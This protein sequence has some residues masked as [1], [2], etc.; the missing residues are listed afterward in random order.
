M[1][2]KCCIDSRTNSSSVEVKNSSDGEPTAVKTTKTTGGLL[3]RVKS[4][5]HLLKAKSFNL[6]SKGYFIH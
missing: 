4:E 3:R 5:C 6:K 2:D 1:A